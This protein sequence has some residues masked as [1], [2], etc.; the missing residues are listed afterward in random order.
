GFV[1]DTIG[2]NNNLLS[3]PFIIDGGGVAI[4]TGVKGFIGPI[5]FGFTITQWSIAADQSGSITIDILP[6]NNPIPLTPLLA[7]HP[8]PVLTAA[9]FVAPPAPAGWTSTTINFNDWLGFQVTSVATVTR[10]TIS[11]IGAKV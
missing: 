4:T 10:V 2:V 7:P 6:N 5:E 8:K 11:L 1:V 9:Q 3:A